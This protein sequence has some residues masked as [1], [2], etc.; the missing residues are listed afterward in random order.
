MH[1]T[2]EWVHS[3]VSAHAYANVEHITNKNCIR[4][5]RFVPL[6]FLLMFMLLPFSLAF[7]LINAIMYAFVC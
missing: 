5:I 3:Y 6:M 2:N 4:Q 1:K 7:L